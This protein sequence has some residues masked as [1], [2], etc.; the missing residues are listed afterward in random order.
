MSK[1]V[2]DITEDD[3]LIPP[4][5]FEFEVLTCKQIAERHAECDDPDCLVCAFHE[6]L[7]CDA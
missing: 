2:C 6:A 1:R 5:P 3:R 4:C 7:I